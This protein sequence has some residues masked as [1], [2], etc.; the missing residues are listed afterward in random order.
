[1]SV[2]KERPVIFSD[3]MVRA[4]LNGRKSQTRRVIGGEHGQHADAWAWSPERRMWQSEIEGDHGRYGHGEW[5]RCPFGAPGE[6]LWVREAW[7]ARV[8][9]AHKMRQGT[10]GPYYR[11]TDASSGTLKWLSASSMARGASRITLEI[12]SVR[13]ERLQ[14]ISEADALCE[15]VERIT[16]IG[17]CRVMG[18]H[19]Y[20]GGAG[21]MSPIESY[22]T[23]WSQLNNKPGRRWEDNPFVWVI[24]F[25]RAEVKP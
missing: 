21:F 2:P 15:G 12:T 11:A 6:R 14:E 19:D 22:R 23:L 24:G 13:V 18:W 1:M 10:Y 16:H 17:P 25:K 20:A 5:V 7:A 8:S 9:G 3:E 4:I